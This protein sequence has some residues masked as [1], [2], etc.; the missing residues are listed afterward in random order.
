M[1][2]AAI[3]V[4][5]VL[6]FVLAT[7]IVIYY[8]FMYNYDYTPV[9]K[10]QV[11][12][13]LTQLIF[14]IVLECLS[15]IVLI[16]IFVRITL[17]KPLPRVKA[18]LA[19][20][21]IQT[22]AP[23]DSKTCYHCMYSCE[24]SYQTYGMSI[25]AIVL[26][27]CL[28]I[29]L[30]LIGRLENW[31]WIVELILF[32]IQISLIGVLFNYRGSEDANITLENL[33]NETPIG[34]LGMD[35]RLSNN[36]NTMPNHVFDHHFFMLQQKYWSCCTF[37]IYLLT[38]L[39]LIVTISQSFG[40]DGGFFTDDQLN[41][42]NSNVESITLYKNLT[43]D[44]QRLI[45]LL[46]D[47]LG[48]NE[49]TTNSDWQALLT[50]SPFAADTGLLL[51][52]CAIPSVS[53]PNWM[54]CLSGALPEIIG[55][56]GNVEAISS[57]LAPPVS[58][59]DTIWSSLNNLNVF[60][61]TSQTYNEYAVPNY[62]L[63]SEWFYS[64]IS[65]EVIP[66]QYSVN[67]PDPNYPYLS[68][69]D[70]ENDLDQARS[71]LAQ[72]I[73]ETQSF[74]LMLNYFS[75][76]DND[77]HRYG[78]GSQYS[79]GASRMAQVLR[80]I[81]TSVSHTAGW[82]N[83]TV[84]AF[85]DHGHVKAGGHGGTHGGVQNTPLIIYRKGSHNRIL[86]TDQPVVPP[87][88]FASTVA[89]LLQIPNPRQAQG[90]WIPIIESFIIG[91]QTSRAYVSPA[92]SIPEWLL[93]KFDLFQQRRQLTQYFYRQCGNS[94]VSLKH[95]ELN[96]PVMVMS[97][98]SS[99]PY[100]T[101]L[102]DTYFAELIADPNNPVLEATIGVTLT[103]NTATINHLYAIQ[104]TASFNDFLVR[105][106]LIN[107]CLVVAIV[108]ILYRRLDHFSIIDN[109][110]KNCCRRNE[111]KPVSDNSTARKLQKKAC[112]STSLFFVIY[113]IIIFTVFFV[114]IYLYGYSTP[115][116]SFLHYTGAI[117]RYLYITLIPG[118]ISL[119]IYHRIMVWPYIDATALRPILARA[120]SELAKESVCSKGY[121]CF[122]VF[123]YYLIQVVRWIFV[124]F[125]IWSNLVTD[126]GPLLLHS[127]CLM[128]LG[129]TM[130]VIIFLAEGMFTC[131]IPA[132]FQ[133]TY[134]SDSVWDARFYIISYMVMTMPMLFGSLI[135]Y[136]CTP[137][138]FK[139]HKKDVCNVQLMEELYCDKYK[140]QER[141]DHIQHS[142]TS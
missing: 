122:G 116:F 83:T 20:M 52:H 74:D 88:A 118:S 63:G 66:F 82:G 25:I 13:E 2:K 26:I 78:L 130:C 33:D 127:T 101:P 51:R 38:I 119:L 27:C 72:N 57:L 39:T 48:Y 94:V 29:N 50:T 40:T 6:Q 12:T 133:L 4:L 86:F 64:L 138:Q 22:T 95:T 87:T 28:A 55:A 97:R 102:D 126:W 41:A 73:I 137:N 75:E 109:P 90:D 61:T 1:L 128:V 85:S 76:P 105:N 107:L 132:V 59:M 131:I 110:Y 67:S 60:N 8:G 56:L 92:C 30:F 53:I 117:W 32:P 113:H 49:V 7:V 80:S 21:E 24:I 68:E 89:A 111:Y 108:W 5:A 3:Y 37:I 42:M 45:L 15:F 46:F 54:T 84:I 19:R 91:T 139:D 104:R 123:V 96:N 18:R 114:A 77:G 11:H 81:L 136:W 99:D 112:L 14:G 106:Y 103:A 121:D 16:L 134:I 79:I 9:A 69:F 36:N 17:C 70:L 58:D 115:D 100:G 93:A 43:T 142:I 31:I 141:S 98:G 62:F 10:I 35:S 125:A 124:D 140:I 71:T 135:I 47:G 129:S 65:R 44:R 34:C 120:Q 23:E